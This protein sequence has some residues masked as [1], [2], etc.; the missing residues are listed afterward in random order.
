M[1]NSSIHI[2]P[3]AITYSGPDAVNLYAVSALRSGLS[4]WLRTNGK[5]KPHRS[6][7]LHDALRVAS[8]FTGQ[9]YRA[10]RPDAERAIADLRVWIAT[11]QSA[12]PITQE[13]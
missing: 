1:S 4:L 10:S 11:M 7:T 12:L 5:L 8:K 6:W 2:S 9:T 3:S 13:S